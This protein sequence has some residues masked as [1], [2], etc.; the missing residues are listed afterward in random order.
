MC[1]SIAISQCDRLSV[2][3]FGIISIDIESMDHFKAQ[4]RDC[5]GK[6]SKQKHQ[7]TILSN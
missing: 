5:T 1:N 2:R 3:N 7:H 4:E 6:K